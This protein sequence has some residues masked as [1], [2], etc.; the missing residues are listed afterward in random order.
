M[1]DK[2]ASQKEQK[3]GIEST[4]KLPQRA[5]PDLS[6]IARRLRMLEERYTKLQNRIQ[7][8]EH[9]NLEFR[10]K[11][12]INIK[13]INSELDEIKREIAEVKD[14]IL[15]IVKELKV[16]AKRE[17]V[18]VLERYIQMWEPLNFITREELEERLKELVRELKTE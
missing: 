1:M 15:L 7:I 18:K 12:N 9:D 11:T 8:D 13:T 5:G 16:A 10:K 6:N 4:P 14:R 17:D 2:K 3:A